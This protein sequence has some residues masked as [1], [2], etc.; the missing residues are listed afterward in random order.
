VDTRNFTDS[1]GTDTKTAG[2]SKNKKIT[3]TPKNSEDLQQNRRSSVQ[4]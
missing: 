2:Q 3:T 4:I 1:G